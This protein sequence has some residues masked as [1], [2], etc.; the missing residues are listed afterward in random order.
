MENEEKKSKKKMLLPAVALVVLGIAAFFVYKKINYARHNEDTE[1]SQIECNI[2]PISFR[3]TGYIDQ[4][5]VIENQ[6]VHKGD[7]LLK[8]DDRDLKI[9]L[10]QARINLKNAGANV[11]VVK[12]NATS[13]N[14]SAGATSASIG[15]AQANVESS[16]ATME[17]AKVRVWNAGENFKR[18]EQLYNQTSATQQQYDAASA[19]KQTAERQL[20][21]A[22]TQILVAEAQLRAAQQQSA[23]S[24]TQATGV[25]TQVTMAEVGILQRQADIDFANLQLSYAYILAPADGYISRKSVQPGQLVNAGQNLM[26][27]VDD[28]QLWVA[29]NFKETQIED[30]KTG[31]EVDIKADAYPGHTFKGKIESIQAATG[32]KFSL[33]PPDNST[34][35]FVKVVQRVPV[36]IILLDDKKDNYVLRAGMNVTVVV[37][38]K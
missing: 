12:S 24:H 9:R 1:N 17:S 23:A 13:A 29:A 10:E 7:T 14:A 18:Y 28:S 5:F 26:S 34:G 37:K 31:Q 38:V 8:L 6:Q 33:L 11:S 15:T 19:E 21:I 35:N 25:G 30:M 4:V 27:L 22:Q 3:I 20:Q 2:I 32:S 16:Q 36:R